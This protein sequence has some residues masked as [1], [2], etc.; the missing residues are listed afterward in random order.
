MEV[1]EITTK[2]RPQ[3]YDEAIKILEKKDYRS[4]AE[5]VLPESKEALKITIESIK[6]PVP[7]MLE[8]DFLAKIKMKD[9]CFLLHA[10]FE[11]FYQNNKQMMKRMLEYYSYLKYYSDLAVYQVVVI[12]K[13]P[14]RIKNVKSEFKEKINGIKYFEYKYNVLKVYEMNKDDVLKEGKVV[15]YPF[16][17]F[18]KYKEKR[19]KDHIKECLEV[20][21]SL[22][23]KDYYFLTVQCLRKFYQKTEY[24]EFVKEEILVQSE[25]F[26]GPY[27]MGIN[28][29]IQLGKVEGI[30]LGKEEGIQLGK[31]EGIQ[32]G[33][34]ENQKE[35][36]KK[37][38]LKGLDINLISELTG[39]SKNEL[40]RL[41]KEIPL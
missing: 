40:S 7:K 19:I 39:L 10:E 30:Q 36:V 41:R 11:S 8:V 23:D 26:R 29:G 3:V 27:E 37:A 21:A 12:L 33:K 31:E 17:I 15:L 38:Y 24:Q 20:V 34:G 9:T 13:K 4:L 35:I 16:R 32:L 18:M 1:K 28:E 6:L 25:L 14:E 22:E 2:I 5:F